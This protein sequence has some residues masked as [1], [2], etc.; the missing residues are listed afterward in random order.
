MQSKKQ[1]VMFELG[2][3]GISLTDALRA[4]GLTSEQTRFFF[5]RL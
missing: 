4:A 2:I 3:S 1:G 5:S